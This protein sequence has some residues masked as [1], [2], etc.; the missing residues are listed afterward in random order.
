MIEIS[1][2]QD[3]CGIKYCGDDL[4]ASADWW[5]KTSDPEGLE[6]DITG[7]YMRVIDRRGIFVRPAGQ[8]SKY[9]MA[10]DAPYDGGAMGEFKGDRFQGH[11]HYEL[12]TPYNNNTIRAGGGSNTGVQLIGNLGGADLY[13]IKEP[14]T[15]SHGMVRGRIGACQN[16]CVNEKSF[17]RNPFI[18]KQN[19]ELV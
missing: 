10:N 18:A 5:Y 8:N 17:E 1:S 6:R 2:Y 12:Y 16:F 15:G 19:S 4:N 14:A 3:L 9:T 11:W 13:Y 7:A